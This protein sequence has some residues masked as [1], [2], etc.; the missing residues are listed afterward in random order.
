[1]GVR[2]VVDCRS[3]SGSPL[4]CRDVAL[5]LVAFQRVRRRKPIDRVRARHRLP[6]RVWASLKPTWIPD[7]VH[8][9]NFPRA[10]FANRVG[11]HAAFGFPRLAARRW[12]A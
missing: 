10:S 9:S 3:R 11:L 1:M 7:V 8:D 2:R 12:S 4:L 5:S 6:G